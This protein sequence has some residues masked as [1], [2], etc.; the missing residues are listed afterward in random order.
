MRAKHYQHGRYLQSVAG[1]ELEPGLHREEDGMIRE[2]L[3]RGA[4]WR[5]WCKTDR[6]IRNWVD[7]IMGWAKPY[8]GQNSRPWEQEPR[9][10]GARVGE[11]YGSMV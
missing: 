3:E 9:Q 7:A 10:L 1:R 6:R 5:F 4:G 11:E 2:R 8:I